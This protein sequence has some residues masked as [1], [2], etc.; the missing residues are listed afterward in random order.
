MRSSQRRAGLILRQR[1]QNYP[2]KR[3]IG[4]IRGKKRENREQERNGD[5]GGG[6][7]NVETAALSGQPGQG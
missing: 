3:L 1:T 5:C 4:G 2:I 6:G 7:R